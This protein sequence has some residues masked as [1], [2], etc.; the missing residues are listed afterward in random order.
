VTVYIPF[1]PTP[2]ASPPFQ[3]SVTLDGNSYTLTCFWN[4]YRGGGGGSGWYMSLSDISGNLIVGKA[5]IASPPNSDINLVWGYFSNS[6][7]VYRDQ[8]GNFEQTP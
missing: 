2:G 6:T 3:T 1:Q 4:F 7:L 5:L 8:T